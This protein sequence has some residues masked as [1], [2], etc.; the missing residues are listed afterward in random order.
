M[1]KESTRD[2]TVNELDTVSG[3]GTSVPPA[4]PISVTVPFPSSG[5]GINGGGGTGYHAPL[6]STGGRH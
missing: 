2:L 1:I 5:M 3:G 6:Q 4:P